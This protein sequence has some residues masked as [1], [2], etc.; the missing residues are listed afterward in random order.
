V[1]Q[2]R[3]AVA[4]AQTRTHAPMHACTHAHT[5]ARTFWMMPVALPGSPRMSSRIMLAARV[6]LSPRPLMMMRRSSPSG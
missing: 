1:A 4:R 6:V 3:L 2:Q 5:R